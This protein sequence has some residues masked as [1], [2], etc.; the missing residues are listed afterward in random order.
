MAALFFV[1]HL[2]LAPQ[3]EPFQWDV[4][5]MT[6]LSTS[7]QSDPTAQPTTPGAS[8]IRRPLPA[9]KRV[10]PAAPPIEPGVGTPAAATPTM[11]SLE[12][13]QEQPLHQESTPSGPAPILSPPLSP[14][15][16]PEHLPAAVSEQ[17][18]PTRNAVTTPVDALTDSS[19][20]PLTAPN[21]LAS[22]KADYG[23]LAVLMA[24]WIADLNKRYPAMLRTEGIQGK[25]TLTAILHENGLL[26]DV[27][28]VKSSGHAA[29]DQ[30][31][32]E[33]VTNGPPITLSRPLDRAQMPV[34]FSINYDLKTAR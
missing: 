15:R 20:A 4:A 22:A 31:A 18:P 28:V 16:L 12:S 17:E 9:T 21:Q 8:E 30:V 7:G 29:L 11:S 3:S 2:E 19:L 10:P 32:V 23:W 14:D 13:F 34:K 24:Q 26:S 6:P 33:D 5:M 25:V 27:R 1:R